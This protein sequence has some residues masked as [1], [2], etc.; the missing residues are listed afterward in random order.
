MADYL[1]NRPF[2]SDDFIRSYEIFVKDK[3]HFLELSCIEISMDSSHFLTNN[4]RLFSV[5]VNW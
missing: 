1:I 4:N 5:F 3:N 2:C